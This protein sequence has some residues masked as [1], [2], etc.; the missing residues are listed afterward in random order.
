MKSFLLAFLLLGTTSLFAQSLDKTPGCLDSLH[1]MNSFTPNGDSVNDVFYIHF[2]C[3]PEKF[4]VAIFNRWGEELYTSEDFNF[5][6]DGSYSIKKNTMQAEM[7][8]YVYKVSFT[9]LGEEKTITGNLT[10]IR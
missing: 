7:G 2:P 1:I 5:R 4:K 10:L 8:V 6:W 3:A 9:Y